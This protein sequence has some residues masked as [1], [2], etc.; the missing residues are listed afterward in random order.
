MMMERE[1]VLL[2]C[3]LFAV[4]AADHYGPAQ[5][6]GRD[7]KPYYVNQY[8]GSS[9][10]SLEYKSIHDF[11]YHDEN[12]RRIQNA[13]T[14]S[15]FQKA[16]IHCESELCGSDVDYFVSELMNKFEDVSFIPDGGEP[17]VYF[18]P[19]GVEDTDYQLAIPHELSG[20]TPDGI[21]ALLGTYGFYPVP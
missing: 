13:G 1:A 8:S 20:L 16:E 12:G 3:F 14:P 9:D 10:S 15:I 6:I 5:F 17:R 11:Y 2:L 7:G 18:F 4:F 21:S 19:L